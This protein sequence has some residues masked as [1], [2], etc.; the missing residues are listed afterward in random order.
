MDRKYENVIFNDDNLPSNEK[1]K[2]YDKLVDGI[3]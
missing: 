3:N 1:T 2:E